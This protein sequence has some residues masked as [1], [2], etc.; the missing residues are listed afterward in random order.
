MKI[1]MTN[2]IPQNVKRKTFS[3]FW[4][5]APRFRG[6]KFTP[7]KAGAGMTK[8]GVDDSLTICL[9]YYFATKWEMI[10]KY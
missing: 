1:Q 6:D 5:P 9:L 10:Q 3:Y 7:A 2:L 4:I 8:R